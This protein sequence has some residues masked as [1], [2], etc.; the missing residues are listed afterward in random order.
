[1][2]S[3]TSN[4]EC[5]FLCL[6]DIDVFLFVFLDEDLFPLNKSTKKLIY[7]ISNVLYTKGKK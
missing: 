4:M 5:H 1:M 6:L 7:A 2:M 3:R